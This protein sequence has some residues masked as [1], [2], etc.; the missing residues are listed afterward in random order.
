MLDGDECSITESNALSPGRGLD[1]LSLGHHDHFITPLNGYDNSNEA[2]EKTTEQITVVDKS[3]PSNTSPREESDNVFDAQSVENSLTTPAII[4][5]NNESG[6]SNDT[7]EKTT[8]QITV[9]DKS[10]PSNTSPQEESHNVN[11]SFQ[12]T[13]ADPP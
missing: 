1:N 10:P 13:R 7:S 8:E 3:P 12:T 11:N 9:V 2:S 6:G 5:S 4:S